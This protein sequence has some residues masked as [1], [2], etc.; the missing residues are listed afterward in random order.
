MKTKNSTGNDVGVGRSIPRPL[1]I[2]VWTLGLASLLMLSA[3]LLKRHAPQVAQNESSTAPQPVAPGT[4]TTRRPTRPHRESAANAPTTQMRP[5]YQQPEPS[6][7]MRSLVGSLVNSIPESGS[8]T[9][10]QAAA[11]RGTFQSL[12]QQ[13][14][15]AVSAISE[16]L[17]KNVD[18]AFSA[19]DRKALGFSSLRAAMLDALSQI[20]GPAGVNALSQVLQSTADPREIAFLGQSLER[21]DP[22][23]HQQE[24]VD[25]AREAL[26]MAAEGKLQN[27]DVAPLFEV[28]Q[29]F[30]GTSAVAD[31]QRNAQKWSYYA[32]IALARLPDETG[33]PSLTQIA[34]GRGEISLETQ[35]AAIDMLAQAVAQSQDARAALVDLV[36]QGKLT[37]YQWASITPMLAGNQMVYQGAAFENG[38]STMSPNDV[39]S[40]NIPASNQRF[41]TAPFGAMTVDQI[42]QQNAFLDELLAATSDP[43]ATQALQKAKTMLANRLFQIAGTAGK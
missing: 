29:Q 11:W 1:W 23:V 20:G 35:T 26:G 6:A 38:L 36:R 15:G 41:S 4:S 9:E 40:V 16:F 7:G 18:I 5:V 37:A 25:A 2:L 24:V 10:D 19:D 27:R 12:V 31:L 28:L 14:A 22:N 34:A 33:I 21:L 17:A 43:T 13:G 42:Q 30:G 39:R 8:L 3:A 32:M